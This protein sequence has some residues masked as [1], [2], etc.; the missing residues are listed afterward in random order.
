MLGKTRTEEGEKGLGKK[1]RRNGLERKQGR[2]FAAHW[3]FAPRDSF[4][5]D[6]PPLEILHF[7]CHLLLVTDVWDAHF[8]FTV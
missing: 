3:D 4:R 2:G 1:R 5:F 7:Y 8:S 6:H